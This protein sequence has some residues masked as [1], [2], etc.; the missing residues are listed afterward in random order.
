[1]TAIEFLFVFACFILPQVRI[2]LRCLC[3]RVQKLQNLID[4]GL[5]RFS[6]PVSRFVLQV[7][8]LLENKTIT[9][10]AAATLRRAYHYLDITQIRHG[11][12]AA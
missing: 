3:V 4:S 8:A 12:P 11:D 10:R 7:M 6:F 9:A 5:F 1:M 2:H